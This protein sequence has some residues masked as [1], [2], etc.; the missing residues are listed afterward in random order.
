[1][2]VCTAFLQREERAK[3]TQITREP[4][5]GAGLNVAGGISKQTSTCHG[6]PRIP[7]GVLVSAGAALFAS[8]PQSVDD[9]LFGFPSLS[10]G[11]RTRPMTQSNYVAIYIPERPSPLHHCTLYPSGTPASARLDL[12]G[13]SP[14]LGLVRLF[15]II[16]MS[17]V[18]VAILFYPMQTV[19][20]DPSSTPS[21]TLQVAPCLGCFPHP[22]PDLM[23]W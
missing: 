11:H 19:N 2:H 23:T 17:R 7:P 10:L 22:D 1:M 5:V 6:L 21:S 13:S 16:S 9:H 20:G 4:L 8:P 15:S 3:L 14:E 12:V 18:C